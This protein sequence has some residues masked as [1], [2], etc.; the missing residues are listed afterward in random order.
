[1]PIMYRKS[2]V[3]SIFIEFVPLCHDISTLC[4]M[5]INI[6]VQLFA[7]EPEFLVLYIIAS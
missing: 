4:S 3:V 6:A 2:T 7:G 5:A 1:M